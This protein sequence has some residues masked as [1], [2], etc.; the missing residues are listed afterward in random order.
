MPAAPDVRNF[1]HVSQRCAAASAPSSRTPRAALIPALLLFNGH[2]GLEELSPPLRANVAATRA[3]HPQY[4]VV[5]YDDA[6]CEA[7]VAQ[8]DGALLAFYR[9]PAAHV[10]SKA[11]AAD[12][13]SRDMGL[14]QAP[15]RPAPGVCSAPVPLILPRAAGLDDVGAWARAAR[16]L[17][18]RAR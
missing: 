4:E 10:P 18:G 5:Y 2:G 1:L 15:Y 13:P 14:A 17:H 11:N 9:D 8:H 3:L 16:Q 7:A 12:E 6:R